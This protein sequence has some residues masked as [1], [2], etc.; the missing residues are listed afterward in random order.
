[1]RASGSTASA[2]AGARTP[3]PT[4]APTAAT[5]SVRVEGGVQLLV[6]EVDQQ[7]VRGDMGEIWGRSAAGEGEGEG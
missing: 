6:G 2:T 3:T 7:L 1:M 5:G 4:A